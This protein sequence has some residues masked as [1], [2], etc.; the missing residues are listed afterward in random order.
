MLE[1]VGNVLVTALLVAFAY[2]IYWLNRPEPG[3]CKGRHKWSSD[4]ERYGAVRHC[5]HCDAREQFIEDAGGWTSGYWER[6]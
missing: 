2:F 1:T 5:L 6:M 4:E 3:P